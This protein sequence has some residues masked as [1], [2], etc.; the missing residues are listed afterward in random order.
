MIRSAQQLLALAAIPAICLSGIA[1]AQEK[2]VW[3]C[4]QLAS[5]G[6]FWENGKWEVGRLN[7]T[8]LLLTIDGANSKWKYGDLEFPA[9]CTT[10]TFSNLITC[11]DDI[12]GSSFV[13]LNRDAGIAAYSNVY[14]AVRPPRDGG[15]DS[16]SVGSYNCTKF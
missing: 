2:E 9:A 3:A 15:R 13:V 11:L 16:P 4:Q 12:L 7:P 1:A 5:A 10:S 8:T 6:L 14:G